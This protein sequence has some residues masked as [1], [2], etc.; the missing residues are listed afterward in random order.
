VQ[1]EAD[2][3]VERLNGTVGLDEAQK[4][5]VFSIMARS[6]R[7]FDP[8]M[9]IE[10]VPEDSG[11]A[12]REDRDASIMAVLRPEQQSSYEQWRAERRARAEQEMSEM[13]L[14]MPEGWDALGAD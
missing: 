11:V 9:Q 2:W 3:K 8:R 13:G 7:D 14:K 4:D 6:S 5:E 10:G 12:S 1:N